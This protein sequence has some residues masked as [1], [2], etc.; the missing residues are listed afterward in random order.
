M[1]L[2]LYLKAPKP[3]KKRGTGVYIRENGGNRELETME[4]VRQHFPDSDLSH[5]SEFVYET[6]NAW[7]GNITYNLNK[8]AMQVPVGKHTLYEILWRP[9]EIGYEHLN[10]EY[11][12]EL[13]DGFTFLKTHRKE[14]EKFNPENGWGSYAQLLYF[15][16]SLV[17]TI[18]EL[19]Y[20]DEQY[21]IIAS[22]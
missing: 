9:E 17:R 8:I 3:I 14:L 12:R 10:A 13:F 19:N 18:S 21:Q 1:S 4:E 15:C 6:D 20:E 2:D 22:R 7:H 16:C 5:I 11:A